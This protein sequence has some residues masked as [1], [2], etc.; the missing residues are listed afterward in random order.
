MNTDLELLQSL[1]TPPDTPFCANTDWQQVESHLGIGLPND[2][3]EFISV[4]GTGSLQSF[5]H[6]WNYSDDQSSERD[7]IN[8]I[9]EV[10][11]Q[12]EGYKQSGQTLDFRPF[13]E[14][15]GLLPFA[16]TDDGNYLNWKIDGTPDEWSVAAYD[17]GSG[18]I[19]HVPGLGMVKCLVRLVQKDNPFGDRFCNIDN[20]NPPCVYEPW[21]SE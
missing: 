6:I 19:L 15:G 12:L 16:S 14:E 4:Y 1:V 5:L 2:Y 18:T 8:D 9:A 7:P 20:F 10:F 3:K 13:P 11:S 21:Q 17:F